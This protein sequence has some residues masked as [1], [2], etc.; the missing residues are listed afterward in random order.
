MKLLDFRCTV[1]GG[2]FETEQTKSEGG[3]IV[4]PVL[5]GGFG[6]KTGTGHDH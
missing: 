6:G 1:I 5:F 4:P 2:T 3:T